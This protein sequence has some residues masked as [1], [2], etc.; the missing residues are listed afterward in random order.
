[1]IK[2]NEKNTIINTDKGIESVINEWVIVR[3][4]SA[5]VWF[6]LVTEKVKD[7]IILSDARRMWEWWAKKSISLSGCALYGIKHDKSL[8]CAPVEHVWLQPI[9]IISLTQIAYESIKGAPEAQES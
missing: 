9:E 7:E 3:T 6:G 4:Y 2:N 8:I 5:G 1:M